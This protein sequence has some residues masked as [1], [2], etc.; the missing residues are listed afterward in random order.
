M[1]VPLGQWQSNGLHECRLLA[2]NLR[3]MV[4]MGESRVSCTDCKMATEM[5]CG[6]TNTIWRMHRST[7]AEILQVAPA[8]LNLATF[9]C[10]HQLCH[11]RCAVDLLRTWPYIFRN[12]EKE[13][14]LD[15]PQ[16]QLHPNRDSGTSIFSFSGTTTLVSYV[17]KKEKRKSVIRLIKKKGV[18]LLLILGEH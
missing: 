5:D 8:P 2:T 15:S 10:S 9:P 6:T 16:F 11:S 1:S 14:T 4:D 17:P 3:I 12:D 13:Q 7:R 18:I